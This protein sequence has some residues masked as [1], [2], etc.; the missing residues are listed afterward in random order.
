MWWFVFVC[1]CEKH[2]VCFYSTW[3]SFLKE[4]WMKFHISNFQTDLT[5][6]WLRYLLRNY[7]QTN[8][9]ER[10][11]WWVDIGSGTK[12]LPEPMVTLMLPYGVT[13]H[14]ELT[15]NGWS[16]LTCHQGKQDPAFRTYHKVSNIRCTKSQNLNVSH[17][18][19]QL[20]LRNILNPTPGS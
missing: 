3:I 12:P 19:L 15:L 1:V 4:I 13:S 11:W 10:Y 17:L 14:N 7:S 20:S 8:V 9:T 6:W 2:N 16:L 5:D 18:G